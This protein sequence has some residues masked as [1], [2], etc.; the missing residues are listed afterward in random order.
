MIQMYGLKQ[1]DCLENK[2]SAP[3]KF[4]WIFFASYYAPPKKRARVFCI[5]AKIKST[6]EK[7]GCGTKKVYWK[8]SEQK[9]T[10]TRD[11][12]PVQR[13]IVRQTTGN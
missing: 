5:G 11:K 9:K 4:G 1:R 6:T 2:F 7:S 8:K 13:V 10:T 12:F 3:H